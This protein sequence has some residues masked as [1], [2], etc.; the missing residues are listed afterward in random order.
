MFL[1]N[2]KISAGIV[3]AIA[4]AVIGFGMVAGLP[5]AHADSY[6]ISCSKDGGGGSTG[7]PITLY[8][9]QTYE[10]DL[11]MTVNPPLVTPPSDVGPDM[12]TIQPQVSGDPNFA[13]V[14][15]SQV[16]FTGDSGSGSFT[17]IAQ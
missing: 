9:G 4:I 6:D 5:A 11:S 13:T 2:K 16:S 14:G 8:V 10:E 7:N 1:N 15:P 3:G 17:I 12:G